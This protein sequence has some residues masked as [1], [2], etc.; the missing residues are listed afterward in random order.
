[1]QS[2]WI[3]KPKKIWASKTYRHADV[4]NSS[5]EKQRWQVWWRLSRPV[6]VVSNST[7]NLVHTQ[8]III[9]KTTR[10]RIMIIIIEQTRKMKRTKRWWNTTNNL[11]KTVRQKQCEK[12]VLNKRDS[13]K[14]KTNKGLKTPW[15]Q[16]KMV[17]DLIPEFRVQTKRNKEQKM[18]FGV[19]NQ[20]HS[21]AN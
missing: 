10:R 8:I 15:L 19:L 1:M 3:S 11:F 21:A 20:E 2:Y 14:D 4:D 16:S 9:T 12:K 6:F 17:K 13:E 7:F 18:N 5:M